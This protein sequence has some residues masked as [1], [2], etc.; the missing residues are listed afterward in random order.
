[1]KFKLN[2]IV[3]IIARGHFDEAGTIS[4]V[5]HG[6]GYPYRVVLSSAYG[7][8]WFGPHELVLAER[9]VVGP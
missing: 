2:D 6:A 4:D 3:R 1:M 8:L 9:P 5:D 7:P